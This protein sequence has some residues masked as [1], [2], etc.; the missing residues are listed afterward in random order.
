[1]KPIHLEQDPGL[2]Q[3]WVN[4]FANQQGTS[5]VDTQGKLQIDSA[6]YL[7]IMKWIKQVRDKG[8]GTRT[9]LLSPGD[10]AAMD[11][12]KK[13]FIPYAIWDVY[14]L[15]LLVKKTRGMWRAMPLPAW[16]K[17]GSRGAVMGGSSFI[18]PKQA[19]NPHLAW[20]YYEHL[21]FTP[22]GYRAVHGP[23]KIYPKGLNTLL[24]SYKPALEHQLFG[25]VEALGNQ[26]LWEIATGTVSSISQNYNYP[27]WYNQA[28]SYFGSNVQRLMDGQFTPEQV[29]SQ[30]ASQIQTKLINRS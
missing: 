20:L 18:I 4:M 13:I 16:T 25:N 21:L 14:S 29:L 1:V 28:V 3:L 7:T 2:T 5:M 8:L 30:S 23:N 26:D 12:G 10:I 17:G 9:A 22:E 6:P 24:P 27:T 11:A 19:K 15:D